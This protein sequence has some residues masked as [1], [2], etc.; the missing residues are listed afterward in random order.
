M[1]R[2]DP[3]EGGGAGAAVEVL[4][5]APDREVGA[6]TGQ[7]DGHRARRVAQVPLHQRAALVRP[8]GD[9]GHVEHRAGPEVDVGEAEQR[10][11]LV[12]RGQ[13]VGGVAPAQ[14][15]AHQVGDPGDDVAVG[16]ERRR[17]HHQH[18]PVRPQPGR[19]HG[20]LEQ[21]DAGAVAEVYVAGGDPDQRCDPARDPLAQ[22][23]PLR[24]V[25]RPDQALAPLPAYDVVHPL[26]DPGREGAQRVPVEV[27]ESLGQLEA[28]HRRA[29]RQLEEPVAGAG[30]QRLEGVLVDVVV[31]GRCEVHLR[32]VTPH[33]GHP[34]PEAHRGLVVDLA[35]EPPHGVL[36]AAVAAR[37]E[38]L[39]AHLR[40]R[41]PS[42]RSAPSPRRCCAPARGPW[43]SRRTAR[44]SR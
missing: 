35:V 14:L 28:A 37:L 33:P 7:V 5:G 39:A 17:L 9:R 32:N 13:R 4:V 29:R 26:G 12:D 44:R 10:D 23:H 22:L 15:E 8:G 38:H 25:P 16:R 19:G 31:A 40:R 2:G 20:G 1:L 41:G 27:D 11:V 6:G 21:A 36:R 43:P 34:H 24:V 18:V 3:E 42:S 30:D